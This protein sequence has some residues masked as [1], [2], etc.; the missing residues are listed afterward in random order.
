VSA[1][2]LHKEWEAD[3]RKAGDKYEGKQIAVTGR[4][5]VVVLTPIMVPMAAGER[6]LVG[7]FDE[8]EKERVAALK[9][10]QNVTMQCLGGTSRGHFEIGLGGLLLRQLGQ[11]KVKNLHVP[12]RAHHDVLWLNVAMHGVAPA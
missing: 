8:E 12:I 4:L 6:D 9:T 2:D 7:K 1:T 5:K 3:H 10:G 11:S